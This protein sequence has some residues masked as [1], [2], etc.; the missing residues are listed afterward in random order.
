MNLVE[1]LRDALSD[2][3]GYMVGNDIEVPGEDVDEDRRR[4]RGRDMT[5]LD[6]CTNRV[7]IDV[8]CNDPDN[9]L[10]AHRAQMIEIGDF[11]EFE[12]RR[13]PAPRFV[14]VPGGF[15]LAGKRG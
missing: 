3:D 4:Y 15:R 10:F 13:E 12:A 11:A 6:I 9:G 14:E 2:L 5:G 8:A 7:M 1:G